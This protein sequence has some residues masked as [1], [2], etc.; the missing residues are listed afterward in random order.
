MT[1]VVDASVALSWC[2]Q[3]EQTPAGVALLDRVVAEGAFA[4]QLWP[5][6]T[7]NGLL[8]AERR[9][10]IDAVLRRRLVNLLASFPISIDGETSERAWI[11]TAMLAERHGLTAYDAAYLELALRRSLPLATRD[12]ALIAAAN[13][14]GS[15]VVAT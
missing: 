10:R 13:A 14:E 4:P 6:E 15:P 9:G 3:D 5:L 8:T 12:N 11:G 1:F 7:L 2:F